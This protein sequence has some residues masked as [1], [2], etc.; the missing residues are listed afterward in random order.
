MRFLIGII[1]GGALTLFIATAVDAPTESTLERVRSQLEALWD[2]II[3]TTSDSL[4]K[5]EDTASVTVTA[6]P[7]DEA[8]SP[9]VPALALEAPAEMPP[10]PPAG[11]S[12]PSARQVVS[13]PAETTDDRVAERGPA[14]TE[15][16]DTIEIL[17]P[18]EPIEQMLPDLDSSPVG[19]DLAAVWPPF[20]SQMSA[21]GFAAQ[22]SRELDHTFRVERQGAGSYQVV[23]DAES[24]SER[25][26]LLA[27]IAEITG[28]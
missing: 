9:F 22:L 25:E 11:A 6:E 13:E 23:F 2:G 4:F 3:H 10:A 7:D 17:E 18:A 28:Q 1:T 20:H 24:P 21:Q 15:T 5:P 19:T 27:E 14:T 12:L 16:T 26:A 8:D